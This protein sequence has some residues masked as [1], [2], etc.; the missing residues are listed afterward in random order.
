MTIA[1]IAGGIGAAKLIEGFARVDDGTGITIIVNVGDDTVMH[2]LSIS[3]DFDMIA[4]TLAGLVDP[5]KRWGITGDTFNCL[6]M[7]GKYD[8]DSAWFNLGDKDIATSIYRTQLLHRG[9][10]PTQVARKVLEGLGVKMDLIPCTND[11]VHTKIRSGSRVLDFQDYFVKERAAPIADEI[12]FNGAETARASPEVKKAL[13]E[14]RRILIA[15]SNPYLSIDPILA[16]KDIKHLLVQRRDDVAFVSPVVA[17]DAIKGPTVK[18]MKER[19]LEPS[20]ETIARHYRDIAS[21]AFIDDRDRSLQ[22]RVEQLGYS[23]YVFDT[24]MDSIQKKENLA[25]FILARLS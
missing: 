2:G 19:G 24:I 7:L 23:V 21:I 3:P 8:R 22:P 12:V 10:T 1:V 18:I 17:G 9:N 4:Y 13:R 6:A 16:I 20:C 15:P 5:V 11:P 25:K 14:A